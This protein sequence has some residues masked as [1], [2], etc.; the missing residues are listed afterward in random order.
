MVQH[1]CDLCGEIVSTPPPAAGYRATLA[2]KDA[3]LEVTVRAQATS[4]TPAT[5][6]A[7]VGGPRGAHLCT[8]C[9]RKLVKLIWQPAGEHGEVEDE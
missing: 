6:D 3:S 2:N 9:L 7:P 1:I 5:D 4:R 8:A